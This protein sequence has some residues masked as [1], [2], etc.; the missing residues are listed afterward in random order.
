MKPTDTLSIEEF[1]RLFGFKP[2][3]LL[4]AIENQQRK[5]PKPFFTIPDLAARWECSRGNVYNVLRKHFVKLLDVNKRLVP[6]ETVERIERM[7]T[8][9]ME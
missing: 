9:L 3:A 5:N 1:A 4:E 7:N 2:Q 6:A 8:K